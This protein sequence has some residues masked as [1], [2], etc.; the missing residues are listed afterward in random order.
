MFNALEIV[1]PI[2]GIL[3]ADNTAG[4]VGTAALISA[5]AG[6]VVGL[7]SYLNSRQNTRSTTTLDERKATREEMALVNDSLHKFIAVLQD[8]VVSLTHEVEAC[9]VQRRRLED[10]I[11]EL[12]VQVG[13]LKGEI[14]IYRDSLGHK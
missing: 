5:I 12:R 2:L 6:L 3:G 11:K 10:E 9:D 1:S 4:A 13:I 7:L 14:Q 8:Q